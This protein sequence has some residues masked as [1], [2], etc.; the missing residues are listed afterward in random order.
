M[1]DFARQHQAAKLKSRFDCEL[2][3]TSLGA[4][5]GSRQANLILA[6]PTTYM[7]LSGDAVK[8]LTR[9]W[10]AFDWDRLVVIHDELDLPTGRVRLKAGGGLGGHNGLVSIRTRLGTAEFRRIRMGIG[11][12]PSK[13]LGADYV[14]SRPPPEERELLD[15]AI[16]T[17]ADA[18][19]AIVTLGWDTA[20]S[21]QT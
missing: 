15:A 4:G 11:R 13:D 19:A 18:I 3:Q 6:R 7:N 16:R 5:S 14:L 12:P 1:R 2:W 9:Q 8:R 17:T 20:I 21:Q 10:R